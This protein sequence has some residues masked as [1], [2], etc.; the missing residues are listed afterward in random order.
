MGAAIPKRRMTAHL[1]LPRDMRHVLEWEKQIS[2]D[3][4]FLQPQI[5]PIRKDGI[6]S[7]EKSDP[8]SRVDDMIG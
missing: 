1:S 6:F 3:H 2:E 5:S 4:L 8:I 7:G